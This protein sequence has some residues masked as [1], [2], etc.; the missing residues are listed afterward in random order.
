M[1]YERTDFEWTAIKPFLPNE[2]VA[3]RVRNR[4]PS[5]LAAESRRRYQA[6]PRER[7]LPPFQLERMRQALRRFRLWPVH[8]PQKEVL[9]L[10]PAASAPEAS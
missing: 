3:C 8:S 5:R 7:A 9:R 1:R 6:F 2:P 10:G 4:R